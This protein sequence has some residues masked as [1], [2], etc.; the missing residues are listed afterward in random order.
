MDILDIKPTTVFLDLKHPHSGEPVGIRVELQSLSSPAV[1]AVEK[2]IQNKALR[3]G[4]NGM[5]ADKVER[6]THEIL[7]AAIVGWEF[8]EGVTLGG[9]K[10]PPCTEETKLE[11][12]KHAWIAKQLDDRLGDDADFFAA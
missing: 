12:V 10:N 4:R 8:A 9:K 11:F 1:R 7:S 6:N 2:R 3:S 5:N